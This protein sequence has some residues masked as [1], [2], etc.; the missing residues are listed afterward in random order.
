MTVKQPKKR[1]K[2]IIKILRVSL[3]LGRQRNII[4][5]IGPMKISCPLLTLIH[6]YFKFQEIY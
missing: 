5:L 2:N 6:F 3:T 1:N 4:M